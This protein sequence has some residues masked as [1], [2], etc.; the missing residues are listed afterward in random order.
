LRSG[1]KCE[2]SGIRFVLDKE[3]HPYQPSIDRIN[4]DR[5]YTIDNVRLVCLI[6][7][8]SMNRWGKEAF[9]RLA[10]SLARR[11]LEQLEDT[12]ARGEIA[13]LSPPESFHVKPQ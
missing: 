7:N 10:I 12:L 11:Y 6:V 1:G 8:Y 2:V 3:T 5:P 9:E 4:N 13:G